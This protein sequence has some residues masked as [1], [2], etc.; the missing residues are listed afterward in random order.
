MTTRSELEAVPTPTLPGAAS[1]AQA[2][3]LARRKD[4]HLDVCLDEDVGSLVASGLDAYSLEYDALP[5]LDLDEVDLSVTVFGRR[6]AAPIV[7]GAMTGGTSRAGELNRRLARAAQQAGVAMALGSQRPMIVDP[8]ATG[9]YRVRDV[10]P[11]LPL[12]F[13]NVGAVQ[14]N[15]GVDADAIRRALE[16]VGADALNVHLNALQ[17]AIQPEGDT[18]FSGLA[19]KLEAFIPVIGVPVLAKEVGAGIS[20]RAAA[21]LSRLPFAGIECSG[22]GGTS[23]ARVESHR[24]PSGS[25]QAEIGRRLA[26]F[27]VPTATSIRNCRAAFGERLVVASGGVRTGMDVAVALALGADLVALARP[28]LEAAEDSEA[29][30]VRALETLLHELRVIAFCAGAKDLRALRQSR[31]LGRGGAPVRL[32]LPSTP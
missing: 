8:A 22:V 12:L 4:H 10:A 31:L 5:E 18:R 25:I 17:E 24:A 19:E 26:G 7:V 11:E 14:L 2:E 9:S 32:D 28:L 3:A 20:G 6:L 23:W 15:Y 29:S 16:A 1:E 13:G 27:G 21:K 30:C